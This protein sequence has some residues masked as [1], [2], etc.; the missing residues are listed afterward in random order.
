MQGHVAPENDGGELLAQ[1]EDVGTEY[2][3][4]PEQIRQE[5]ELIQA[6]WSE[7]ERLKRAGRRE[8]HDAWLPPLV[9]TAGH[10]EPVESCNLS[11]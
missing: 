8:D 9:R 2:L 5:C 7:S 3:P 6:T 10:S 1:E 11:A 4:T